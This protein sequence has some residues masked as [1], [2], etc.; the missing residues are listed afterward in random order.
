MDM[1]VSIQ[2]ANHREKRGNS[3]PFAKLPLELRQQICQYF[4]DHCTGAVPMQSDSKPDYR[5]LAGICRTSRSLRAA[6]QP[7]LF[8]F[9]WCKD[10]QPEHH[11]GLFSRS[12]S[13]RPS[14][15]DCIR[16]IHYRP[17]PWGG[18]GYIG[19]SMGTGTELY[20]NPFEVD[21]FR[22]HRSLFDKV[23]SQ[24]RLLQDLTVHIEQNWR[25]PAIDLHHLKRLHLI[26]LDP[27]IWHWKVEGPNRPQ[28]QRGL[29]AAPQ[30]ERLWL[31]RWS[32]SDVAHRNISDLV[33]NIHQ[34]TISPESQN[35][36]SQVSD[37]DRVAFAVDLPKLCTFEF[38]EDIHSLRREI[39]LL[40][41]LLPMRENLTSISI[42]SW[43][44]EI[45]FGLL[46]EFTNLK[47][48]RLYTMIRDILRAKDE[49]ISKMTTDPLAFPRS[50]EALHL[51]LWGADQGW[52]I[53]W[54]SQRLSTYHNLVYVKCTEV[55]Y[56]DSI[57]TAKNGRF[58][59]Y[60]VYENFAGAGVL[61]VAVEKKIEYSPIRDPGAFSGFWA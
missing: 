8:H 36:L 32:I 17:E 2:F 47:H 20:S 28:D 30:L 10:G 59:D 41:L 54:L 51:G 39:E 50:L 23:L 4:C 27:D 14:L 56:M 35:D 57:Q 58:R 7:L 6:A 34:L 53:I 40:S 61:F 31:E 42:Q 15:A 43:R 18:S 21:T 52:I 37:V 33:S 46:C 44:V 9:F 3:D 25:L 1:D 13:E 19:S 48:L 22:L 55:N 12:L 16:R 24:A 5:S 38:I 49:S 45:E 60:G 11:L 29:K 26:R